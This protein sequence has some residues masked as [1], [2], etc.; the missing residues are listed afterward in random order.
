MTDPGKHTA[1]Y[2]ELPKDLAGLCRVVQSVYVHYRNRPA[3]GEVFSAER[4]AQVDTRR[5]EDILGAVVAAQ[6][7]ALPVE[8]Q[9]GARFVGCCRDAATLLCSFLRHQGVPA[10]VRYGFAPYLP[11]YGPMPP[12]FAF[13]HAVTEVWSDGRWRLVDA[14]TSPEAV[15]AF[16][17]G[18]DI[19]D[20]PRDRF[21]VAGRVWED[22]RAR[23]VDPDSFG[24]DPG[25]VFRGEYFARIAVARDL[26]FLNKQEYLLWDG[27]GALPLNVEPDDTQLRMLD[28]MAEVSIAAHDDSQFAAIRDLDVVAGFAK[29]A[30]FTCYSPVQGPHVVTV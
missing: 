27:W 21:L 15:V 7:D 6:P 12:G 17:L 22:I 2:D 19:L 11:I 10:R 20:I 5:V 28:T 29:P 9:L 18:F 23:R 14:D 13:D 1:L 26:H 24:I 8:R 30:T 4:L 25:S 3:G 16:G